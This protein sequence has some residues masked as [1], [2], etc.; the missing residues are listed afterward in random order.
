VEN[1]KAGPEF[2]E[3]PLT[4]PKARRQYSL[5]EKIDIIKKW[6]QIFENSE[7][8]S[9]LVLKRKELY[10]LY[11][12]GNTSYES[13]VKMVKTWL[14]RENDLSGKHQDLRENMKV[15]HN[16]T[17]PQCRKRLV[18]SDANSGPSRIFELALLVNIAKQIGA[19]AYTDSTVVG[20]QGQALHTRIFNT[21][22]A[23]DKKKW[24]ELLTG[25]NRDLIDIEYVN[26][27]LGRLR[28]LDT[29]SLQLPKGWVDVECAE[30]TS[31]DQ[32]THKFF[33]LARMRFGRDWKRRFMQ[34]NDL[35]M[36]QTTG[37]ASQM[38]PDESK[39][40]EFW[41]YLGRSIHR[42]VGNKHRYY[43]RRVH[44]AVMRRFFNMDETA[45]WF[46]LPYKKTLAPK[47]AKNVPLHQCPAELKKRMT[48]AVLCT[49]YYKPQLFAIANPAFLT[50]EELEAVK[51]L[52]RQQNVELPPKNQQHLW[53]NVVLKVGDVYLTFQENG[54]MDHEL[55]LHW[56]EHV[57]RNVEDPEGET[58][59]VLEGS[60]YG[61]LLLF[62]L[63]VLR[64]YVSLLINIRTNHS[65]SRSN[66]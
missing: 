61:I 6:K 11:G 27:C 10:N 25:G 39:M 41:L 64:N 60:S 37:T 2:A 51:I 26:E 36:R 33:L 42:L 54:W 32:I 15:A 13:F 46:L 65:R 7:T 8:P 63:G 30:I 16:K 44:N 40:K 21:N 4:T 31:A 20:L 22:N 18:R 35:L 53:K 38:N 24:K 66:G 55:M 45:M 28:Q 19:G 1:L 48:F 56:I 12:N 34:R 52:A 17:T 43:S 62:C 47:G 59:V 50:G 5:P 9:E 49:S 3:T 29:D 57:L 14:K 23:E 58:P